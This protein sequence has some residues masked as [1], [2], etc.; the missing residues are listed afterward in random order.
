ML[1][2]GKKSL[3]RMPKTSISG[4]TAADIWL[5]TSKLI[6]IFSSFNATAKGSKQPANFALSV[7]QSGEAAIRPDK[8][9]NGQTRSAS[10]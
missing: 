7:S 1:K 4:S 3:D 9:N 8:D 2:F 10:K 5:L 6:V